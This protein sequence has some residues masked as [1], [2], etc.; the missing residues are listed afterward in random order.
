MI[1]W[2]GAWAGCGGGQATPDA[3]TAAD[4]NTAALN[5]CSSDAG[6][7]ELQVTGSGQ[8]R[9][10]RAYA[11]GTWD[12]VAQP[13]TVRLSLRFA[14]ATP[15]AWSTCG[16]ACTYE[17]WDVTGANLPH[18]AELGTY[19]ITL[20]HSGGSEPALTGTLTV[21]DFENPFPDAQGRIGG[22]LAATA[23][24][25]TVHGMFSTAFCPN[26]LSV[27]LSARSPED[28]APRAR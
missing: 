13:T 25:R 3:A 15:I 26:E 17:Y 2:F 14:N 20:A 1:G 18:G 9:F 4:S 7:A 22:V 23:T 6:T 24:G 16:S 5:Q 21:T 27:P 12:Y 8:P 10:V 11:G 19:P 28:P